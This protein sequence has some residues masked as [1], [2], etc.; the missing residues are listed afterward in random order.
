M[1]FD[2]KSIRS[3][4]ALLARR[5]HARVRIF[6]RDV[7]I[8]WRPGTTRHPN[9]GECFTDAGAWEFIAESLDREAPALEAILLHLPPGKTGY[10]LKVPGYE[11]RTI[12]IKLQLGAGTVIARSF[13]ESDEHD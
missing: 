12:Y 1:A 2:E 11:K 4:L 8:D 6:T 7:P 13:H 5:P 9:S 10:V 3:Q